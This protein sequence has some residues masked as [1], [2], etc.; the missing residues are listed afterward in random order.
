MTDTEKRENRK[1]LVRI[2]VTYVATAYVFLGSA[3]LIAALWIDT[4]D[5]AKLTVAKD[6]YMMVLPVA[7]GIITYWFASRKPQESSESQGGADDN[8][9][10]S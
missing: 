5:S 4:L 3:A 2:A 10:R 8:Q 9:N 6:V 7:T 1:S